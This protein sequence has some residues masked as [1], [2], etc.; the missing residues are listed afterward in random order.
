MPDRPETNEDR[1]ATCARGVCPSE[2]YTECHSGV[3]DH[4]VPLVIS[5]SEQRLPDGTTAAIGVIPS[6]RPADAPSVP[7]PRTESHGD[8]AGATSAPSE[9][10]GAPE[11]C[12]G[13]LHYTA[14]PDGGHCSNIRGVSPDR[15]C[16][17]PTTAALMEPSEA[18]APENHGGALLEI[19]DWMHKKADPKILPDGCY[20][21]EMSGVMLDVEDELRYHAE[22]LIADL[23][24]E[25]EAHAEA[26]ERLG[27]AKNGQR[28][29]ARIY[30][31]ERAAREKAEARVAELDR[32]IQGY[33]DE[34][35][36][37]CGDVA[38]ATEERDAAEA[39]IAELEE[40]LRDRERDLEHE[41]AERVAYEGACDGIARMLWQTPAS[42]TD[43][44]RLIRE[45]RALIADLA[46]ERAAREKAE[47]QLAALTLEVARLQA[48]ASAVHA[49]TVQARRA[50]TDAEERAEQAAM[51]WKRKTYSPEVAATIRAAVRGDG[52]E[53]TR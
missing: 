8:E 2:V 42:P 41:Y 28:S 4:Y 47:A 13:C 12:Q 43:A 48:A 24:T 10:S 23:A 50:M 3:M 19:L 37:C 44:K 6:G 16:F 40:Q 51:P 14:R 39:R 17:V 38:D 52:L 1:C 21:D 5:Y 33:N 36:A 53:K 34:A 30:D 45:V 29:L 32:D 27:R 49:S 22:A 11:R 18:P 15:S 26:M 9:A 20:S 31:I 46:T 25:R 7:P 35:A